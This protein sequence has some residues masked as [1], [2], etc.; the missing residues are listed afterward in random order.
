MQEERRLGVD[1]QPYGKTFEVRR[2]ARLR[3]LR[4]RAFGDRI[5]GGSERGERRR[6]G[7]FF[8]TY[9]APNNAVLGIVGD[10]DTKATLEK[11][12]RYFEPIPSQPAPPAVDM[13][14]PAQTAERRTTIRG[15]PGAAD[16][17]RHGLQD[18]AELV[19]RR[20]RA[21]VL[22]TIL[23]DGRSRRVSTRRSSGRSSCR[24][25]SRPSRARAAARGSSTSSASCAGQGRRGSR[26]RDRRGDRAGEDRADRADWEMEK[27]R[28]SA[29]Q[30]VRQQPGQLAQ[31]RDQLVAGR[32]LLRPARPASTR[33][34]RASPKSRAADVQ[35]VARQYLVKTGRTVVITVPKAAPPAKGG[36]VMR[37]TTVAVLAVSLAALLPPI[38]RSGQAGPAAAAVDRRMVV[39]GKA[40]VSNEVLEG[41]AAAAAG[42]R[43]SPTGC[44]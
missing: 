37:R 40:P 31:T 3:E 29:A 34:P 21:Q 5:D 27:A 39:K 30:P 7:G 10:V 24:P 4:L 41:Q 2:R 8:K 12:R 43:R 28:T 1:N 20:R 17:P 25:T 19:A 42:G 44:T 13:T 32:A 18:P 9:Y 15:R 35:R 11:V 33:P 36:A 16:A 14:E 26:S 6:R 38:R 22:G 23:S